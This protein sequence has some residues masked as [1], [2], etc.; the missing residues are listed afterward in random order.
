M[1]LHCS[2]NAATVWF[3]QVNCEQ[4][5]TWLAPCYYSVLTADEMTNWIDTDEVQNFSTESIMKKIIIIST[6]IYVQN[7]NNTCCDVTM[8]VLSH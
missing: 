4:E 3:L 6:K 8:F 7:S 1:C 2:S 5:V